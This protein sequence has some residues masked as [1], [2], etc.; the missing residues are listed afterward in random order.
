MPV[1]TLRAFFWT[2]RIGTI[3]VGSVGPAI[4]AGARVASV[5]FVAALVGGV[6][7][8]RLGLAE[9]APRRIG[10]VAIR[11]LMY[12]VG[13]FC[14]YVSLTWMFPKLGL[15]VPAL[16]EDELFL[17]MTAVRA[18]PWAAMIGTIVRLVALLDRTT[19]ARLGR[20]TG[21]RSASC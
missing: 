4:H 20:Q 1:E 11:L 6:I 21:Q 8:W 5:F 17:P 12:C 18:M 2:L 16:Y 13:F 7:G 15:F 14:L 3:I 9:R 19:N 10:P